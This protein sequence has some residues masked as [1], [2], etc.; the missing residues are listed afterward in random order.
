MARH[1]L[2]PRRRRRRVATTD[3]RG[4]GPIFP[5]L[6]RGVVPDGPDRPC[7]ADIA[8]VALA[9][10]FAYLA[11]VLDAWSRRVVGYALGR[12]LDARLTIAALGR[13]WD[14][15]LAARLHPP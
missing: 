14:Q 6:V 4:D 15:A 7:V 2:Q 13:R 8:C 9:E 12:M 5:K 10:G 11:V 1:G 3:G